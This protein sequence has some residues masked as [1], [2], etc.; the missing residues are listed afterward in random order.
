LRRV[1]RDLRTCIERNQEELT[2]TESER[3]AKTNGN[4]N[5]AYVP[6][7][8]AV[9]KTADQLKRLDEQVIERVRERP[10]MAVGI[11]LAAGYVLGRIFSR[12]G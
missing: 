6:A 10:I 4:A 7:L 9:A 12:W 5:K 11:A 2:V 3:S 8:E 1:G